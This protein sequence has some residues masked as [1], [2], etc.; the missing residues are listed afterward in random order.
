M[1]CIEWWSFEVGAFLTGTVYTTLNVTCIDLILFCFYSS[2]YNFNTLTVS[3]ADGSYIQKINTTVYNE[4]ITNITVHIKVDSNLLEARIR[5][6]R[7]R[8]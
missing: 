5:F 3:Y 6:V 1:I 2:R 7:Y 8:I 4:T